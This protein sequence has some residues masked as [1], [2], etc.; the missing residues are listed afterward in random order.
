MFFGKNKIKK[1]TLAGIDSRTVTSVK[2]R[3]AGS[4]SSHLFGKIMS[5]LM[6]FALAGVTAYLLFFSPFLTITGINIRGAEKV[7]PGEIRKIIEAEINGK[8]LDTLSKNNIILASKG[9]MTDKLLSRF[10]RLE[11]VEIKKSFPSTLDISVCER[12]L[13]IVL[14][15][16][17]NCFVIDGSGKAFMQADFQAGELGEG[18]MVVM[19]D[20]GNKAINMAEILV[21]PE[22]GQYLVDIRDRL[23]SELGVDVD[24]QYNTPQLISG[25]IRV[26]TSEGWK[27]YFDSAIP[28]EKEIG[29]L[30]LVLD[31]KIEKDK[32]PN[33]E[34]VDLRT[35]NKVYYKFKNS[36]QE[37]QDNG[38]ADDAPQNDKKEDSKKSKKT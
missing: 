4:G 9:R 2:N 3:R 11:S 23:K 10:K 33:L 32:R 25:D 31:E 30:K 24:R 34:Y 19:N 15:S 26:T 18:G 6:L 13:L 29:T 27:I 16:A 20:D 21:S 12:K 5:L 36:D 28:V 38:S 22:Y 35:E 8:Y 17:G 1:R 14:C 7:N 37:E